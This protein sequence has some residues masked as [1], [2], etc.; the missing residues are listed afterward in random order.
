MRGLEGQTQGARSRL[1]AMHLIL[2]SVD[3]KAPIVHLD[4]IFYIDY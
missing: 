1:V 4:A 3:A 2:Q